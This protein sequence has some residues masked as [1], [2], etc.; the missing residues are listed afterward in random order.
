MPDDLPLLPD[1]EDPIALE[2]L[3]AA[4]GL[5]HEEVVELVEFGALAFEQRGASWMFHSRTLV[6][7]RRAARLRDDFGLNTPGMA[8][9]LAY[10]E[11]IERLERRLRELEACLPKS[12]A[13]DAGH[14]PWP[15]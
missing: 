9:A 2:E 13:R 10:L 5:A 3:M 8:V 12:D 14:D 15:A 7:A 11:R 6:L 1:R 4:S